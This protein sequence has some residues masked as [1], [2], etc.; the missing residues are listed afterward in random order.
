MNS[1]WSQHRD[2]YTS[3]YREHN[4]Q[5][6]R[7]PHADVCGQRLEESVRVSSRMYFPILNT[8]DEHSSV[9]H[10][11]PETDCKVNTLPLMLKT[12]DQ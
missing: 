4:E 3:N 12:S 2:P 1:C 7:R 10:P 9:R 6:H 8:L 11:S 5:R